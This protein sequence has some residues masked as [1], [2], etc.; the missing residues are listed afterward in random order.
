MIDR[1]TEGFELAI[2]AREQGLPS[3]YIE[4]YEVFFEENDTWSC[5]APTLLGCVS[6][7][8]TIEECKSNMKEAISFHL[9]GMREDKLRIPSI[10]QDIVGYLCE[11]A[12]EYM[13][14][15]CECEINWY[16]WPQVFGSTAGPR[17]GIGGAMM[18]TFQVYAF[19][20]HLKRCKYCAGVWKEWDGKFAGKW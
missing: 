4:G 19:E 18:T 8:S 10:D 9:D 16:S 13:G 6:A 1:T 3:S 14:V 7:G 15:E 12:A 2:G 20:S 5:F 11:K 17:G